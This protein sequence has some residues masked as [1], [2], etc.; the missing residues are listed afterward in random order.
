M[1][2]I[3]QEVIFSQIN[4]LA[5]QDLNLSISELLLID[6]LINLIIN[7]LF[8]TSVVGLN[9]ILFIYLKLDSHSQL[10]WFKAPFRQRGLKMPSLVYYFDKLYF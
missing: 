9:S 1:F 2:I 4:F 7:S 5:S 10:A 6:L 3:C 8:R